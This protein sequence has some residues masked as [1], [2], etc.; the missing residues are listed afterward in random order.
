[1]TDGL[2]LLVL[3][4]MLFV[5][6]LICMTM[7]VIVLSVLEAVFYGAEIYIAGRRRLNVRG[8]ISFFKR[9]KS[10]QE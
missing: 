7:I 2:M 10:C 1:M 9:N 4:L 5:D 3:I 8:I 6:V